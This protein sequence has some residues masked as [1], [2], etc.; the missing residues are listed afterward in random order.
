MSLSP[1]APTTTS[2]CSCY[3]FCLPPFSSFPPL[4][5]PSLF[6]LPL[7]AAVHFPRSL[8]QQVRMSHCWFA[9]A[10][11]YIMFCCSWQCQATLLR[12]P[13]YTAKVATRMAVPKQV[14]TCANSHLRHTHVNPHGTGGF[15]NDCVL[16]KMAVVSAMDFYRSLCPT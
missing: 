7:V 1:T 16:H 13:C 5:P 15:S 9:V 14:C 2:P 12:S 8:Q 11:G 3:L 6:A 10:S 4:Q